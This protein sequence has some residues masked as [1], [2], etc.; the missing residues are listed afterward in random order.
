MTVK[1]FALLAAVVA[2]SASAD[3]VRTDPTSDVSIWTDAD[4]AHVVTL[5]G[6]KSG[7]HMIAMSDLLAA[8]DEQNLGKLQ[9]RKT[10]VPGQIFLLRTRFVDGRLICEK[11]SGRLGK[12]EAKWEARAK[13][14]FAES[15]S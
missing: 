3:P 15:C 1:R 8:A 10:W 4:G 9:R 6:P 14:L 2:L 7:G 13:E 12:D 11:F 5:V